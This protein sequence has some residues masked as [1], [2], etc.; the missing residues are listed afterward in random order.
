LKRSKIISAS[1]TL[2]G[3]GLVAATLVLLLFQLHGVEPDSAD[4]LYEF[5]NGDVSVSRS[6][7]WADTQLP[8]DWNVEDLSVSLLWYRFNFFV[9]DKQPDLY[10]IYLPVIAQNAVVYLNGVVI[11][12]AGSTEDPVSRNW[13]RP[14]IFPIASDSLIVG[15]NELMLQVISD[16]PGRG[17]L[18]KFYFGKWEDLMPAHA[19]R[20][21]LKQTAL[22]AAVAILILVALFLFFI[23]WKRKESSEY[24]WGAATFLGLTGHSIQ[25]FFK[26]ISVPEFYWEWWRHLCVGYTIFF[27]LMFVNRYFKLQMKGLEI[28]CAV[29]LIF[30]SIVSLGFSL[31]AELQALYF[32]YAGGL[33]GLSSLL[34][35]I[36]PLSVALNN[37]IRKQNIPALYMLCVGL[38]MFTL[39]AHDVLFVNGFLTRENGFLIHYASPLVAVLLTVILVS[40]LIETSRELEELNISLEQRVRD[41]NRALTE[42][43]EKVQKMEQERLLALERERF[44]RDMHDGLGGHLSTALALAESDVRPNDALTKTIR[45]ATDEMRLM[46]DTA[47]AMSENIGMIIGSLRQKLQ[48]QT[49]AAGFQ[50]LWQIE[51][52]SAINKLG[53]GTALNIIRIL[54]EAVNNSINHS[55]GDTI[56]VRVFE[57]KRY[58]VMELTDSGVCSTLSRVSGKG[59]K[60]L[61]QRAKELGSKINFNTHS[62]L[63]GLSVSVA[64]R[65]CVL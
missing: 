33:W 43:Y 7:D 44:N 21:M 27:M 47:E 39:G 59:I 26:H 52:T 37:A 23:T 32:K 49:D 9:S 11:G 29:Y 4:V 13:P 2:S 38:V 30:I 65:S 28:S 14:L 3:V 50:L 53:P 41:S 46:L 55:G 8:H 17:L 16:L 34:M 60:N 19:Y 25:I 6:G 22:G 12:N 61:E 58:V 35:G 5:S 24:A 56:R 54:Q 31:T 1:L 48:R 64:I 51:N 42:S 15:N 10:A 36:A 18:P 62:D 40:R 20:K 45:D 57:N 63:G